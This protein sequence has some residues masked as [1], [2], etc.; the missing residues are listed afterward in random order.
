LDLGFRAYLNLEKE[1]NK[2]IEEFVTT[3]YSDEVNKTFKNLLNLTLTE[4]LFD[5]NNEDIA[6]TIQNYIIKAKEIEERTGK[7]VMP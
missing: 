3:G 5:T 7:R 2:P 4:H 6:T 1:F